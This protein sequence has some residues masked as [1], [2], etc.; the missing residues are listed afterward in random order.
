MG[1]QTD[2]A[3]N[4]IDQQAAFVDQWPPRW[5]LSPTF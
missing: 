1:C 4:I 2:I 3:A 5:W